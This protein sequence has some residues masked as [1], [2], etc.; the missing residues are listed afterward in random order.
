MSQLRHDLRLPLVGWG[1]PTHAPSTPARPRTRAIEQERV[2]SG[3][4]WTRRYQAILRVTDT[5]IISASV[6][7]AFIARFGFDSLTAHSDQLLREYALISGLILVTWICALGLSRTRDVK[8]FGI[9]PTEYKR[10]FTS[11]VITF[12]VL[13]VFFVIFNVDIA[14]GFFVLALPCGMLGLLAGRWLWRRWLNKKRLVGHY[15]SRAVVVGD[16]RDIAHVL[17]QLASKPWAAFNVVGVAVPDGRAVSASATVSGVPI[18][19]T[20][21]KVADAVTRLGADTVIV[22]G[23]PQG[24]SDY[25]RTLGWRLEGS[26][27]ELVLATCLTDVAGPRIH[28][29]PVEGLPLIHVDLPQFEGTKHI[30]KRGFDALLS[31]LALMILAPVVLVIAAL[32]K[33][34]S[35]GPVLFKQK[36]VGQNG[37]EFKMLKFRSMIPDA[38]SALVALKAQNEGAGVLFKMKD[39]PRV[40]RLGKTL[41]KYSLDELPQLWNILVGDMSL[42]GPRPPLPNEVEGYESHVKRRLYIKPGLTGLWQVS[43][44]SDLDWEQSVKLDLYYVENWSLTG[45]LMLL[46]RTVKVVLKPAGAY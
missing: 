29:R 6:A 42:V 3:R 39:D 41:R 1:S 15:L 19:A 28:F 30:L 7:L 38:E 22:A 44:R 23:T 5:L 46:W 13:A 24:G 35:P 26:A 2:S 16:A 10:V 4:A 27:V 14:R 18:V 34:D 9:G 21:E 36:R 40:T 43:G 17:G 20:M 12:G 11:S 32:I 45:D 31:G 37:A 8:V 33:L 25:I